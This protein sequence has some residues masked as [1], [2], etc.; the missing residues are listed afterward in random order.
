MKS[1]SSNQVAQMLLGLSRPL[2]RLIALAVDIVLIGFTV[3]FSFYL[4]LGEWV[5]PFAIEWQPLSAFWSALFIAVPIFILTGLYRNIFRFSGLPVLMTLLRAVGIY[6]F[7]YAPL[8]TVIGLVGVPRTIGLIQPI[9]LFLAIAASRIFV[10]FWLGGGYRTK[11]KRANLPRVLIYGAGTTGRQLASALRQS[12]QMNVLGFLDDDPKLAGNALNGHSIFSVS[13]LEELVQKL[14]V[15]DVLLALPSVNRKRRNEIIAYVR[16]CRVHVRT[17]P[18][19]TD[20]AKGKI[21]VSDIRELDIEDLLGR[22]PVEPN[23]SLLQKNITNKI[24]LVTGAGGSIGSELCRQ[25]ILEKPTKLVLF[26]Q[27]EFNLYRLH[28]ELLALAEK[29]NI[30]TPIVPVL[31]SVRDEERLG[32]IF[33]K[34]KPQT[35]YHAAA[36]KH[37]PLV[38]E[39]PV[40]GILNNVFGTLAAAQVAAESGAEN[41][42]LISTDKAVRPTNVM[43]ATKRLAEMV[44]QALANEVV[45]N[46]GNSKTIFSMV[47]FGNVLDSSGSVVPRF[48]QQIAE[49]G[50]V[51]LTHPDVTRYFMTIPEAAQLV[52]QASAMAKGGDVF[53]LDMGEPVKIMELARRIIDL[54][55]LTV[56]DDV[57][58][59]GDIE[60]EIIGLRPGEKLYEELLI[61]DDPLA[62][63]NERIMKAHEDYIPW[64]VF[65]E[66]LKALKEYCATNNQQQIEVVLKELVSGYSPDTRGMA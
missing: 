24:V 30:S 41:F 10:A 53:L 43:G 7:F 18:S 31:G 1:P 50:P 29:L 9:L 63:D 4:R 61:A 56:C 40:E 16:S 34:E 21:A 58:S 48:K 5:S 37:V 55:G 14:N 11:L 6:G 3:W 45:A 19:M 25:I 33:S 66:K 47:R 23:V 32:D 35:I 26:E 44:L 28:Q 46:Q 65:C 49:G 39:N 52:I 17:L 54:S 42:T 51:T 15:T 2:K 27:G 60:I 8:I 20:L 38:E 59:N 57:N 12:H 13:A 64:P 36:Y 62:T 22:D